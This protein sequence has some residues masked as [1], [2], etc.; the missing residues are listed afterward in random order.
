MPDSP[1]KPK[2]R[3]A[4]AG[5]KNAIKHGFYAR[6]FHQADLNDLD[7]NKVESLTDE[8]KLMRVFI[9]RVLESVDTRLTFPQSTELLRALSLASMS[10]N[11]LIRTQHLLKPAQDSM[12][13]LHIALAKMIED[14]ENDEADA[15]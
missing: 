10:V 9:R 15:W 2:R 4:P 1:S 6:Q 13:E 12:D 11:R 8:I 3:G 7:D 5:N 14:I